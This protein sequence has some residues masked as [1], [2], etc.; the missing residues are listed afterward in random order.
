MLH[1]L[2]YLPHFIE[3]FTSIIRFLLLLDTSDK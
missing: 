3:V 1:L 2:I